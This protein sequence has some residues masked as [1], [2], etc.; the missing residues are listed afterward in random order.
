MK[1]YQCRKCGEIIQNSSQPKP[2]N[3]PKEGLHQWGDLGNVG[4]DNYECRKCNA[5]VMSER[6]PASLNCTKSGLHQWTKL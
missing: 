6:Q 4:N 2:I 5:H 3:C 1:N